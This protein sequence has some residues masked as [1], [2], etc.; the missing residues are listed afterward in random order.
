MLILA[1]SS[2]FIACVK[3]PLHAVL[4]LILVFINSSI[5][6]LRINIDFIALVFVVVYVGA[7]C[8]LFLFVIMILNLRST[9]LL[10][11]TNLIA[12]SPYGLCYVLFI[13]VYIYTISH[14]EKQIIINIGEKMLESNDTSF[15]TMYLYENPSQFLLLTVLLFLA[16]VAPIA[17]AAK[18]LHHTKKQELFYAF[19]RMPN[20]IN[21]IKEY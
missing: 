3:H 2:I 9:E 15:I 8:I 19:V 1:I 16:I 13:M 6:L 14:R 21:L 10:N 18:R 11:R 5:F 4:G 7:I 17:I 20:T 12:M